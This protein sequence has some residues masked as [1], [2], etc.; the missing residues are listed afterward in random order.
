MGFDLFQEGHSLIETFEN[1][2]V[3]GRSDR[4]G[5]YLI[6]GKQD[7]SVREVFGQSVDVVL[8]RLLGKSFGNH[9]EDI[10][11]VL[12]VTGVPEIG[13]AD[14]LSEIYDVILS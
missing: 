3:L 12:N 4:L 7:L 2:Y 8:Y 13:E 10:V 9:G 5:Y 6:S 14:I 11:G 1:R